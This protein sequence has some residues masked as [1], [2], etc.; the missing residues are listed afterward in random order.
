MLTLVWANLNRS[1]GRL[2]LTLLSVLIAFLLFGV[3]MALRHGFSGERPQSQ[4][5]TRRVTT[6]NKVAAYA[7]MPV[8]YAGR[9]AAVPG[10]EAVTY[11]SAFAGHYRKPDNFVLML[12]MPAASLLETYPDLVVQPDELKTWLADRTGVVVSPKLATQYGWHVGDHIPIESAIRKRDG[13]STWDVTIDGLIRRRG[14][15]PFSSQRVFM[16]YSYFNEARAAGKDTVDTF[17]TLVASASQTGQVGRAIDALF[18]NASPQTRTT[19][20]NALLKNAY[21]AA[22]N[23]SAIL[24]GAAAAV[25]FSMLLVIGTIMMHAA[26][27]RLGEF[28]VLRAVGFRKRAVVGIVFCESL[29]ISLVGGCL[30]LVLAWLLVRELQDVLSQYLA[31][32][33][34]TRSAV[35][36]SIGLML[37]TGALSALAPMIQTWRLSL[38]DTLEAG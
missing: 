29:L 11:V 3:L 7:P 37:A 15:L 8:A 21:A 12:A 17:S 5:A 19:A 27:E 13:T 26:R 38:R 16:H 34:L 30:G 31:G 2:A 28:A 20:S 18:V 35:A 4:A 14:N 36:A 10:V 22:G 1:K 25:F 24:I 33:S 9:I 6:L 23:V 32:V